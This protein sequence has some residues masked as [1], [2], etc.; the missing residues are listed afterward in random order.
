MENK[1][2]KRYNSLDM[3]ESFLIMNRSIRHSHT[4]HPTGKYFLIIFITILS[5]FALEGAEDPF[6]A[7]VRP[8]DALTPEM[9][10]AAFVLPPGFEMELVAAEP[11]IAKPMN[12]AFDHR[13]RLWV[14][15]TLEY[16]FPAPLDQE[17]RDSIK[18]LTDTDG[19]GQYDDITTFASGL[20]IPIGLYPYKN[21]VLVW[22]IPNIWWLEDTDGDG[23]ADKKEKRYGPL[24]WERDTHGMNSSF[25]RGF[26]GWLYAT[27]GFNNN[28]TIRGSDGSEVTMNSGNTYR[29]RLDG[30]RVEQHTFGQVNP[31]G[32]CLDPLGNFYTADCH[33]APVYQ[34]LRGAYYPSFGKPHDGLGFGPALMTHAHGSTAICGIVYYDDDQWPMEFR[35]NVFIGN[36][37][38]S[39]LNRDALLAKGS[40][41]QAVEKPDLLKT[42]DPWFR[43][44][45]LQLGPDGALYIA[46]F[47]NKIIGHYEV[48]LKHPGRD[49][50]RG[51]IWKLTYKGVPGKEAEGHGLPDLTSMRLPEVIQQLGHPNITRRMLATHYLVDHGGP[52]AGKRLRRI[53]NQGEMTKWRQRIHALWVM[54][55][56]GVATHDIIGDAVHDAAME[57]RTHAMHLLAERN[58]WNT[59]QENWVMMALQDEDPNVQRAAANALSLHPSFEHVRPLLKIR[60][61]PSKNDPQWLHGMRLSL[62]NQLSDSGTWQRLARVSLSPSDEK[63]LADVALA[64]RHEGAADYLI[65]LFS[66]HDLDDVVLLQGFKHAA[67]YASSDGL[68]QLGKLVPAKYLDNPDLQL[69][70]FESVR[71]GLLARGESMTDSIRQWGTQLAERFIKGAAEGGNVWSYR[72]IKGMK[73]TPNP[74]FLQSRSSVD[75]HEGATFLCS[76]PPGGEAF[77][78]TMVSQDFEAPDRLEFF[79]AGHDGYPD[80]PRKKKNS[81]KLLNSETGQALKQ[82]FAPRNDIARRVEWDLSDVQGARVRIEIVDADDGDAYAWLAFGRMTPSVITLPQTSPNDHS[83]R[84]TAAARLAGDLKL[85]HLKPELKEWMD[86]KAPDAEVLVAA[87]QA[88]SAMSPANPAKRL[89]GLL[90]NMEIPEIARHHIIKAITAE[91]LHDANEQLALMVPMLSLQQQQEMV[92]QMSSRSDAAELAASWI[93]SGLVSPMTLRNANALQQIKTAVTPETFDRLERMLVALPEPDVKIQDLIDHRTATFTS[94]EPNLENGKTLFQQACAICHQL[95]K[96]GALVGPQLDGIGSRGLARI[97]EDILAP[98]RNMDHAFQPTRIILKDGEIIF[99]LPRRTEGN[100]QILANAAGQEVSVDQ[101]NIDRQESL[102]TSIMPDNF[103]ELFDEQSFRDLVGFLLQSGTDQ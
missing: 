51:R 42:L 67:R 14:T 62:R 52:S 28:T 27:H 82:E 55:R 34:L 77:T 76:L 22:S 20:N 41:R 54:E 53:W 6:K 26:D 36:V 44:V 84:L 80:K 103:G 1:K 73:R 30:S 21:G 2:L 9:E 97:M 71:Q 7:G 83:Q 98:N 24:G 31:F 10:K 85:T 45:N 29:I 56:L 37:M 13:G 43:P 95:N 49:R 57:V 66:K 39:R 11:D 100:L 89:I 4:L 65:R 38:T 63:R 23:K 12:M 58:R 17:G 90:S 74:W 15:D 46:D 81:V 19:D 60:E 93:E 78:G 92:N 102:T 91:R 48:P 96:Q 50:E 47:Y 68:N 88:Y 75:G 3:T 59:E 61:T 87:A 86:G 40:S 99:G 5:G 8:T 94:A 69:E 70:L 64:V 72:P 33:S 79:L 35:E 101:S 25:T 32:M 18:V 16:P